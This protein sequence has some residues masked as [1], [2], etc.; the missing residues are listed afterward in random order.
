VAVEQPAWPY[1][2]GRVF[3][4][5]SSPFDVLYRFIATRTVVLGSEH[6]RNLPERVIFAGTH[7]SYADLELVHQGLRRTPARGLV[8]RL[9]VAAGAGNFG[10]AGFLA[11][12]G[13][14][15]FGLYP[16]RQHGER[17]ASLRQLAR[18]T[19]RGNALLIFPQGRHVRPELEGTADASA[20]FRPGVAHLAVALDAVVVPFGLAGSERVLPPHPDRSDGLVIAGIPVVVRRGPLAIAFG[21]PLRPESGG[22]PVAFTRRLQE[23]GHSEAELAPCPVG[24]EGR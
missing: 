15:A 1:T 21:E 20:S 22:S 19:E 11:R 12:L 4:V 8:N 9:V 10:K 14:L 6:L 3:R 24:S 23:I 16:L 5:L 2:W 7:H 18:L 13:V 17:D